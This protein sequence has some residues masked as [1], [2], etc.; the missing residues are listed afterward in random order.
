[1]R[2]AAPLLL[3]LLASCAYTPPLSADPDTAAYLAAGT[4][5]A[6]ATAQQATRAEYTRVAVAADY[7]TQQAVSATSAAVAVTQAA[8]T[9]DAHT[10]Q[11]A[12]A[13][14]VTVTAQAGATHAAGVAALTRDAGFEA[15]RRTALDTQATA[16]ALS[17]AAEQDRSQ[18]TRAA[19]LG[20]LGLGGLGGLLFV[21]IRLLYSLAA[22][23]LAESRV[24]RNGRTGEPV[25]YRHRDGLEF[26][27]PPPPVAAL[28]ESDGDYEP[29]AIVRVNG[30]RRETLYQYDDDR[31]L[32]WRDMHIVL[33]QQQIR[34]LRRWYGAGHH[35]IRRDSSSAG[36]GV[37]QLPPPSLASGSTYN[38][39]RAVLLGLEYITDDGSW[40][41]RGCLELLNVQ[42][43]A[44]SSSAPSRLFDGDDGA[45]D[46]GWGD[47]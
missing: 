27:A 7:A 8:A 39:L 1:M 37:D 46:A 47:S 24:I 35:R 26:L 6:V 41:P 19:V 11:A 45:G 15:T 21:V 22:P 4:I 10:R 17:G 42:P 30:A 34:Q 40:T 16:T 23:R 36:P 28:P 13:S 20:W 32:H 38:T 44:P 5:E 14:I 3:L 12:T 29:P 33:S 9:T 43:V 25:A 31:A 18:R 2:L